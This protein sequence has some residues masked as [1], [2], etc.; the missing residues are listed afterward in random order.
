MA[1]D[2]SFLVDLKGEEGNRAK[3]WIE[4]GVTMPAQARVLLECTLQAIGLSPSGAL[5]A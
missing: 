3:C 5:H 4:H 2:K 1:F